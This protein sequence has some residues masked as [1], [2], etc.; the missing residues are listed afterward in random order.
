MWLFSLRDY[1][2]GTTCLKADYWQPFKHGVA[3]H[4]ISGLY[5]ILYW[6]PGNA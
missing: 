3:A 1:S 6:S 2:S 4:E 5:E